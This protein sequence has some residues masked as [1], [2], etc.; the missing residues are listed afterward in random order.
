MLH[1]IYSHRHTITQQH[2]TAR[3]RPPFHHEVHP[4]KLTSSAT[5]SGL[6]H[7]Q[8]ATTFPAEAHSLQGTLTSSTLD[9]RAETSIKR[10]SSLVCTTSNTPTH[11]CRW[12][13]KNTGSS[14]V[15][16][17]CRGGLAITYLN[18]HAGI[19]TGA[20]GSTTRDRV[21]LSPDPTSEKKAIYSSI[22]SPDLL[23]CKDGL[24]SRA[25]EPRPP[26]PRCLFF[27]WQGSHRPAPGP[28]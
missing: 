13:L 2:P 19:T 22:V 18:C 26:E 17:T 3:Q 5:A 14:S 27:W 7:C 8:T 23:P 24:S 4:P 11:P 20:T 15:D 21:S 16:W 12:G 10:M 28:T 1:D 9:I 25:T 6:P